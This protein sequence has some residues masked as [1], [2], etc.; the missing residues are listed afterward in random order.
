[1]SQ[2]LRQRK[3]STLTAPAAA[4]GLTRTAMLQ[5]S[6]QEHSPVQKLHV[7]LFYTILPICMQKCVAR[8]FP[9]RWKA[10]YL[11]LL[12][13]YVYKFNQYP[14]TGQSGGS[15]ENIKGS[16]IPIDSMDVYLIERDELF[17]L[18]SVDLPLGYTAVLCLSTL[19]KTQYYAVHDREEGLT[20]VNSLRQ[21]KE[22]AVKR[23][24]GHAM[25]DSYPQSWTYYDRL[26]QK[27]LEGKDR[28]K[29]RLR[30]HQELE[31]SQLVGGEGGPAP[32]GYYS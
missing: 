25:I 32:R 17:D 8:I 2:E 24:M 28:I 20:W 27:A 26:G 3:S 11:V 13:S 9:P 1:M 19:T 30:D 16:P 6:P 31:M 22:E 29:K 7:P 5:A 4:G 21:A 12:G 14:E 15:S 10:R 23:S 18:F